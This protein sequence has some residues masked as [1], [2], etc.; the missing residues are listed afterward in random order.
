MDLNR[1]AVRDENW[2]FYELML[3][4]ILLDL[5]N[6]ESMFNLSSEIAKLDSE[7][8]QKRDLLLALRYLELAV[9]KLCQVYELKLCILFDEFDEA[10]K[11]LP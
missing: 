4:S 2:A 7:V 6:H 11:T 1:L 5:Y 9:S 3:S 8:F 10:Y